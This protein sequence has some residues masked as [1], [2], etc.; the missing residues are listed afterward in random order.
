M[1]RE[2]HQQQQTK[3]ILSTDSSDHSSLLTL[4]ILQYTVKNRVLYGS[5]DCS[6]SNIKKLISQTLFTRVAIG[7]F[8]TNQI[9]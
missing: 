3:H 5:Y 8:H 1:Q 2:I 9:F 4:L 6:C 7:E